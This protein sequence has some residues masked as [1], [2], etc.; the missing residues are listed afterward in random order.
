MSL[1]NGVIRITNFSYMNFVFVSGKFLDY[2]NKM[3]E[4][5]WTTFTSNISPSHRR[6]F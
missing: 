4:A 1:I 6:Q 3:S 5:M 2:E